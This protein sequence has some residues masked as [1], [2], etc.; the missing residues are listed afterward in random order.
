MSNLVTR[1]NGHFAAMA[2]VGAVAAVGGAQQ[3][4]A[5][6]VYSGVVNLT[7]ANSTNGLYLNVVTGAIN[8]P[9]NTGGGTVS[10][11]D[12]N[13]Y[14]GSGLIMFNPSAPAGGV[15]VQR[16]GGG[17]PGNLPGGQLIDAASTYGAG[18]ASSTGAQPFV[19]SSDQNIIGFRFQ[20]EAAANQI[21]YGWFRLALD[22]TFNGNR[23]LV[24]YAYENTGAGIQAGAVPAPT[25]GMALL[26][27]GGLGLLG[28]RRK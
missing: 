28:R 8:E 21:Q 14:S 20:N 17:A 13:P 6:I 5:A 12:I 1:L 22:T 18:T 24:E 9:G 19:F 26:S 7:I 11:W 2:A 10:G 25:A 3:A 4:N 23:R 16:T 15:Y 27:L